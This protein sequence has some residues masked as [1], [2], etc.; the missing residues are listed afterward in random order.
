[1]AAR[2]GPGPR[3][4]NSRVKAEI[5]DELARVLEAADV[6][7]RREKARGTD[8]VHAGHAHQPLD[9]R[10]GERVECD[11]PVDLADLA[12]EELDLAQRAVNALALLNWQF[13]LSEEPQPGLAEQV[14]DVRLGDQPAHQHGVN[15]VLR[16]RPRPDQLRAALKTPAHHPRSLI[17]HPNRLQRPRREQ[18][19]ERP[20]IQPV[21]LCPGLADP[22][23]RRTH[24][25]NPCD[26][27]LQD[28]R[29]LTG[30]TAHLE[31]D[32]ILAAKSRRKLLER[33]R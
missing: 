26:M 10:R 1:M 6:T 14:T 15:L 17:S 23:V 4:A 31:R 29:D 16:P 12:V 24:N 11:Q 3:L 28:P 13:E 8:H 21:S 19:R 30:I 27:P 25:H 20:G 22:R 7:D 2:A 9:L 33:L 32:P 5:A 18:P